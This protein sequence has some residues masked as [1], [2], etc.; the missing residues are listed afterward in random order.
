MREGGFIHEAEALP[1]V[2]PPR[3][4]AAAGAAAQLQ[5]PSLQQQNQA[6]EREQQLLLLQQQQQSSSSICPLCSSPDPWV[7]AFNSC[8]SRCCPANEQLISKKT[9][10]ELYL[11]TDGDLKGLG[12]LLRANPHGATLAPMRLFL[13][14]QVR[15]VA[16]GR[17]GIESAGAGASRGSSRQQRVHYDEE[18]QGEDERE[19]FGDG[20][21][22]R[23]PSRN[24]NSLDAR[25]E[26]ARLER[27]EKR[28]SSRA[29]K[30]S[31]EAS[32]GANAEAKLARARAKVE[33]RSRL[34]LDEGQRVAKKRRKKEKVEVE[35]ERGKKK[36]KGDES[37]SDE[38]D[39]EEEEG[40]EVET[41]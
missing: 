22:L 24:S 16:A 27:L 35:K 29:A 38:S 21:F 3:R 9:A 33:E 20:G 4:S 6:R 26:A 25:L 5:H 30:R 18:E 40:V 36:K 12:S 13:E 10:K 7:A 1:P 23:P 15:A 32:R 8:C 41:I 14:S 2:V 37:E 11:L 34:E 17:H 31:A 19:D 39:D 28:L